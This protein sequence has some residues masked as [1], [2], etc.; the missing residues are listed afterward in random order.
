M[1][2][3]RPAAALVAKPSWWRA[4]A[5]GLAKR[6]PNCGTGHLF[7]RWLT[8]V[9]RCPGCGYRFEREEGFFLGAFVV[10]FGMMLVALAAFIAVT[11]V[12]TLPDPPIGLLATAGAVFMVVW[13]VLTYP[14]SKTV[15]AAIHLVM[16]PLEPYEVAE[17][18]VYLTNREAEQKQK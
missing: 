4:L 15:W 17:A 18:H 5:R 7:P 9:E 1:S 12:L 11:V 16:E 2:E 10:N 3:P 13:P 6:C 14:F 8:M